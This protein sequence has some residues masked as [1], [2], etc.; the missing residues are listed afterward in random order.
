M[1][2]TGSVLWKVGYTATFT[3]NNATAV[4]GPGP[5]STPLFFDGKLFSI[6]MT[7]IVTARDAA[8]GRQLWQKPGSPIMPTFTTHAGSPIVDRGVVVFHVGG[9]NQGALTA[10]DLNTG[11]VKWSWDGDGPSY[12]SPIIADL[13]GT[14][15]LITLTQTKLIGVDVATGS[16]LWE[17][18]FTNSSVTNAATPVLL[19]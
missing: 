11:D 15:Q 3:M 16:L 6:G 13:E 7:G 18:P 1:P 19:G 8:T 5:K 4:H 14:R 10:F 12:G 2:P 17:R 9:N